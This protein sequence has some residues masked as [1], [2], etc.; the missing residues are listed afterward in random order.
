MLKL[1]SHI[2]DLTLHATDGEI[3][4]IQEFYFDDESWTIRYFVVNTG[5]WLTGRLV[6]ISPTQVTSIN[7][8]AKQIVLNLTKTQ[9]ENSP[10]IDT[11]RP[12]SRQLEA[13]FYD[14][15][16]T[17]YYW[18]GASLS[19]VGPFPSDLAGIAASVRA[20]GVTKSEDSHLRS[21]A[22][23]SGY[24]IAATD[25]SIG[26]A[27]DFI[28][29]DAKW[30][31]RY[32]VVDTR[33]WLPGKK[34][35]LSVDWIS[36]VDWL[37]SHITVKLPKET[38]HDAPEYIESRELTRDYEEKLHQHYGLPLYWAASGERA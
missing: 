4:H 9:I 11:H 22:A 19:G 14:Y 10:N 17:S 20:A 33:N 24:G 31:I 29:D 28:V 35:L 5:S 21:T 7:W 12:I 1:I 25:G 27:D 36:D 34:V 37:E 23:V 13:D 30:Q 26:H 8:D 16:G 15:Y 2:K 18:G 3:G 6:L 38:I 32:V